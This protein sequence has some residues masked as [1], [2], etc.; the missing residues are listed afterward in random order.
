MKALVSTIED[1]YTGYR[2]AQVEPDDKIFPVAQDLFW[3]NC[4]DNVVADKYWYD[5]TDRQIK[6]N[7][8][9]TAEDNQRF[10]EILLLETD[11]V[12]QPDVTNPQINP[13][14]LNYQ[15][16]LN[17]RSIVRAVIVN[18][19]SGIINWPERPQAQWSTN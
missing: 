18:K 1:R 19:Q 14:L 10:A 5:P 4:D 16:F 15:D 9:P 11:W 12:N 13:H 7:L 2:I 8:P 17:Y 3:V 6:P